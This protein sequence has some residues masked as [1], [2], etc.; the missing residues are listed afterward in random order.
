M[1][2]IIFLLMTEKKFVFSSSPLS[3][4][5]SLSVFFILISF[6]LFFSFLL[7]L[8]PIADSSLL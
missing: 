2:T 3:F 8:Q 4:F 5:L 7:Y 1:H 6:F